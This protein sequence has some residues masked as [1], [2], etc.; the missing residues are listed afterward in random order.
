MKP[1]SIN[2]I[3]LSNFISTVHVLLF[4]ICDTILG[5]VFFFSIQNIPKN[6]SNQTTF[7]CFRQQKLRIAFFIGFRL[8]KNLYFF[9]FFII[10]FLF[11]TLYYKKEH[12]FM[13]KSILVLLKGIQTS[14]IQLE[15]YLPFFSLMDFPCEAHAEHKLS[16]K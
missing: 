4:K 12:N 6:G 10:L 11:K 2:R 13:I 16:H 14:L 15:M 9:P 1:K 7:H 3:L 5:F 8:E